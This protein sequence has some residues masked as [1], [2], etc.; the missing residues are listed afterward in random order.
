M[1]RTYTLPYQRIKFGP[2]CFPVWGGVCEERALPR[3]ITRR[4]FRSFRICY[5]LTRHTI[6]ETAMAKGIAGT[7]AAARKAVSERIKRYWAERRK[8]QARLK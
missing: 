3:I 1:F 8:A 7:S 2:A 5:N 6:Q 4:S